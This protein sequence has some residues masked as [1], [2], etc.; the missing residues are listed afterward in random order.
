MVVQR[1]TRGRD[2][3]RV[4]LTEAAREVLIQA[5]YDGLTIRRVAER[6]E[7]S[8]GT[9]YGYFADKDDLL[10][11]LVREDFAL[12]T[13]RLRS[14]RDSHVGAVAVREMLLSYVEMGLERPQS[15]EIMF[16]LKPKL[17]SRNASDESDEHAYAI[18]RGCIV[19]AM[20]RGEFRYDDPDVLA[21]MLWASVHGL[22]SLRL[23]L[24]DFPWGEMTRLAE[25]L[26]DAELRGLAPAAT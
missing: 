3:V 18:F 19:A 13:E 17:A 7:Y 16:M 14:I 22:V 12:L 25:T 26:V 24:S 9:V 23:T 6:A 5:G 21:Q 4:A 8:L 15:Y 1:R 20:R 10:Y 2:G 11:A